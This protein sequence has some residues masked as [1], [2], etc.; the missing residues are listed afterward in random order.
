M[1]GRDFAAIYEQQ[2]RSKW[3]W[4]ACVTMIGR[5]FGRAETRQCE[6]VCRRLARADCC[7]LPFPASC[8]VTHRVYELV[9]LFR[10]HGW[11]CQFAEGRLDDERIVSELTSERPVQ[12]G[13]EWDGSSDSVHLAI[14]IGAVIDGE[15][16]LMRVADPLEGRKTIKRAE[17]EQAYGFGKWTRSWFGLQEVR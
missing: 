9:S 3:C 6:V 14:V 11:S 13:Y 7:A 10:E 16:V 5:W 1:I 17:V 12:V 8:N 2:E 4:A 15:G